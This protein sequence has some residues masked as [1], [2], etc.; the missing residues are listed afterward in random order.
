MKTIHRDKKSK[1]ECRKRMKFNELVYFKSARTRT[2]NGVGPVNVK[3][4]I[5][6]N[7]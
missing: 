5:K 1:R 3:K 4:L 6:L 7:K 2:K